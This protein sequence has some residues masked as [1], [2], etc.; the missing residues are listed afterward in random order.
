MKKYLTLIILSAITLLFVNCDFEK[1]FN[2]NQNPVAVE[3]IDYLNINPVSTKVTGKLNSDQGN[4]ILQ[5]GICYSINENPTIQDSKVLSPDTNNGLFEIIIT[6]LLPNTVYYVRA[7]ATNNIGTAYGSVLKITT[8][9][10]SLPTVA[11]TTSISNISYNTASSGGSISNDGYAFITSKGVCWSN[12]NTSPTISNNKTVNGT[13]TSSFASSLT[14]LISGST[15][16]VRAYATNS[17]GTS[18]GPVKTF[19]TLTATIP[20]GITTTNA[21]S[22]NQTT[23]TSGGSITSNGGSAITQKGICWSN[24]NSSPTIS[25]S[26]TNNGT[27]NTSYS[28]SLTGLLPNTTYYV[29]AYAQ[30]GIGVGYGN[31]ITF[32]TLSNLT[33]GQT[34][35]GGIIAYILVS[36]DSG[37]IAGQVHGLIATTSNQSTGTQWGCSGTSIAGTSTALGSG[38]A[39][40]NAIV[41]GCT[42]STIAAAICNNLT[43]GGYSDWY[44]P[45]REE[46]NKLYL[47]RSAI[48]G[49]S[50]V[51]YWSSSQ[52][53]STTANS[54][55]FNT[56][57]VTSTSTKTTA[58]YVRAIRK[59]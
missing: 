9:P 33:V 56:G 53:N 38:L 49:F 54:I 10:A 8:N 18:Y 39:N 30:N 4:P 43:S 23:A 17:V 25:N 11:T 2:Y 48:G 45:S 44:L 51:P 34:Y 16:Y 15:Y 55:N 32:T 58:M 28:S 46:L 29:R 42:T 37:Y 35:Q 14:S 19:T 24:T 22:I 40:T 50:G 3:T 31:T 20:T 5:K 27:G 12:T 13:G 1:E 47:N 36:G 52:N 41:G 7:F 59:F 26:N 57:I 21:S 6:N